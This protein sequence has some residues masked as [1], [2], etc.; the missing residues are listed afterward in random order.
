MRQRGCVL[1]WQ[2]NSEGARLQRG[3]PTKGSHTNSSRATH[4][5]TTVKVTAD[6]CAHLVACRSQQRV[7]DT[8]H[9]PSTGNK[10]LN[11]ASRRHSALDLPDI[12]HAA[13]LLL[14]L[15]WL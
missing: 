7:H 10:E 11:D 5:T 3:L 2:V 4:Q 9:S 15:L 8:R 13:L 6:G 12:D 14:L 1:R